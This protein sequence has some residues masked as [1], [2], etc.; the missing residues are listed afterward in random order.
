MYYKQNENIDENRFIDGDIKEIHDL[1]KNECNIIN[2]HLIQYYA[3]NVK[4]EYMY[5]TP[6]SIRKQGLI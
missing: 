2:E 1:L 6:N 3:F 5:Y 4:K